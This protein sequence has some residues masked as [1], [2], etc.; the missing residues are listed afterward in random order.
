M[1]F[2]F[3]NKVGKAASEDEVEGT[4]NSYSFFM[5]SLIMLLSCTW[6]VILFDISN[7]KRI[8]VQTTT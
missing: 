5:F 3:L 2:S 8:G 7:E 4:N 1:S 6:L